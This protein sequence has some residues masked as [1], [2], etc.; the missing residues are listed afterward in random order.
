[1]IISIVA[2]YIDSLILSMSWFPIFNIYSYIHALKVTLGKYPEEAKQN[3]LFKVLM[4][5]KHVW[6]D[7]LT[8]S[9][10]GSNSP[11][12][13]VFK[14]NRHCLAYHSFSSC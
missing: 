8:S 6:I 4:Q 12:L 7:F 9:S 13:T 14:G 1:M 3:E 2:S 10:N 5:E 11:E